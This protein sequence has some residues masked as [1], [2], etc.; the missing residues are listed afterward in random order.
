MRL[1]SRIGHSLSADV[2]TPSEVQW[3]YTLQGHQVLLGPRPTA[4]GMPFK[5]QNG[6]Y[7]A[8]YLLDWM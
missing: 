6:H 2:N 8:K 7:H 5:I 1:D 3:L 4:Y